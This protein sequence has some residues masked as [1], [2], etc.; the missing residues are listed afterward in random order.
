MKMPLILT[1]PDNEH[2]CEERSLVHHL[3]S[4]AL[5]D[6]NNKKLFKTLFV[7]VPASVYDVQVLFK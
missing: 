1:K 4:T 5:V 7:V 2:L 3:Y 6:F